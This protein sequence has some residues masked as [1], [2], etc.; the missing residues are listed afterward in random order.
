MWF[1]C[2]LGDLWCIVLNVEFHERAA[3]QLAPTR[4]GFP[5]VWPELRKHGGE[6]ERGCEGEEECS[7]HVI[8][9]FV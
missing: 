7:F 8:A 5:P 4:L 6:D 9:G 1:S 3:R 2:E